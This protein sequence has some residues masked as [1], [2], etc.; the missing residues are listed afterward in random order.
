MTTTTVPNLPTRP[1]QT[2]LLGKSGR[3]WTVVLGLAFILLFQHF[4]RRMGMTG[5]QSGDWSHIL[6]VPF[7]SIYYIY[8]NRDR[9]LAQPRRVCLWGLPLLVVFSTIFIMGSTYQA[10]RNDMLQGY[11]MIIALFGLLL[12]LFGPKVMK[13]LLFP[14]IFLGFGV[15]VSQAFWSYVA[16]VL[17]YIAARGSV[18]LL[19]M[20]SPLTDMHASVRG[21]TIDLDYVYQGVA[22][23][24]P[25]NVAE[26]CSGMRMLM[27]F[28]ALGAALAFLFPRRW[29]Q[30]VAL[31]LLTVPIAIFVNILRISIL[32]L[33]YLIDPSYAQGQFH[34]F[35]G[36]L[37]LIPAAGMLMFVGWC[38]EKVVVGEYQPP[39]PKPLPHHHDPD[40]FAADWP[41]LRRGAI[42][43]GLMMFGMGL[44]YLLVLNHRTEGLITESFTAS[45]PQAGNFVGA[46][47][48]AGAVLGAAAWLVKSLAGADN[49]RRWFIALGLSFGVLFT[50]GTG[51]FGIAKAVGVVFIKGGLDTRHNL[52]AEF[53]KEVGP[54]LMLGQDAR[55]SDDIEKTLDATEY[56]TRH[57]LDT[58]GYEVEQEEGDDG[59]TVFRL[60]PEE[61]GP[62]R[63]I[64]SRLSAPEHG[65]MIVTGTQPGEYVKVHLAY[66]TAIIDSVPHVPDKCWIAAGGTMV[67]RGTRTFPLEGEQ[68]R[69]DPDS[70]GLLAMS[71]F[72]NEVRVPEPEIE[73]VFFVADIDGGGRNAAAYFFIAN[74]N[75]MASSYEVRFGFDLR[76]KYAYYCKVEVSFPGVTDPDELE[77]RTQAFLSDMI[78]EIMACLPDWTDVM[79]GR[80]PVEPGAPVPPASVPSDDETT[81]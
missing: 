11:S 17:L 54:W 12:L 7:I 15:K 24:T 20:L 34:I 81:P 59:E 38:L 32:A 1:G 3:V 8:I 71:S 22:T 73:M 67:E 25:L 5:L 37:M 31:I 42:L 29:W 27:A 30:R 69:D 13:T 65:R 21:S 47:V 55:L 14:V 75:Y 6:V 10:L 62:S 72:G 44:G 60:Y 43:G 74:G 26:A 33:L 35:I 4:I 39:A 41:T 2:P 49:N 66:Y 61:G 18:V 79:E 48:A 64:T 52:T 77:R 53:P 40:T 78:P 56:F 57:Y 76:A 51:M 36:M 23:Q 80:Y 68:Y 9:I 46:V 50:A 45:W 63:V 16:S 19:N 28:L 70:D 58:T